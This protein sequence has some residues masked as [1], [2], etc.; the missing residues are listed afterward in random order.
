MVLCVVALSLQQMPKHSDKLAPNRLTE[1]CTDDIATTRK[2][3]ALE[4]GFT[5]SEKAIIVYIML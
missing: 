1:Y 3:H 4:A 5:K 2:Q